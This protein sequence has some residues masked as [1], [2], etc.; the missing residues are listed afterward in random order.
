MRVHRFDFL[1]RE[2]GMEATHT[3]NR[4]YAFLAAC[5]GLIL[6]GVAA[7]FS[8]YPVIAFFVGAA[9]IGGGIG[10]IFRNLILGSLSGLVV[11]LIVFYIL[12]LLW[13]KNMNGLN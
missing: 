6:C 2:A 10:C 5:C 13:M 4:K 9:A 12:A 1:P 3:Q 11:G 8:S 7:A